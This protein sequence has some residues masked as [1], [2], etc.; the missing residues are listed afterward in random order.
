[1]Q[2]RKTCCLGVHKVGSCQCGDKIPCHLW[3]PQIGEEPIMLHN[4]YHLGAFCGDFN[5]WPLCVKLGM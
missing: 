4:P 3:S 2:L 5:S 1:M